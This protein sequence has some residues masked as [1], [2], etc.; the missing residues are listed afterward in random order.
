MSAARRLLGEPADVGAEARRVAGRAPGVVAGA[1]GVAGN[2]FGEFEFILKSDPDFAG[3]LT[4][5]DRRLAMELFRARVVSVSPP[6]WEPPEYDP[7]TTFGLLVLDGLIGRRVRIGSAIGNELLT[8]GDI[9][10]PW[11]E[12]APWQEIRPDLEWR[13]YAPTRVAVLDERLTRL[14][15]QRP[16]LVVEFSGRLL[17][18]VHSI[19]YLTAISHLVLVEDRLLGTLWHL[20]GQCGRVSR[21]GVRV[22]FRLTHE[23]LG[24]ILGARR[25]S[26]TVAVQKLKARGE[27][28]RNPRGEYVLTGDPTR[29]QP[30]R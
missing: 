7:D 12:P 1:G 24:E 8:C 10:R 3:T 13:V 16:Q 5:E 21:E 25:P 9:L 20:A 17:R 26:V 18:R 28:A 6:R 15:G 19:S 22:P 2:Q 11:Q 23:M 14:I 4:A 29:W 30:R 27:I